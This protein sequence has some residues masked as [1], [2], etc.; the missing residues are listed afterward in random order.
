VL[1]LSFSKM[2]GIPIEMTVIGIP[3]CVTHLWL[4]LGFAETTN[5]AIRGKILSKACIY[6][7][8][9][10]SKL[11]CGSPMGLNTEYEFHGS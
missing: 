11:H 6:K 5:G 9:S 10:L 3:I 8:P 2:R 4:W 1:D 7:L